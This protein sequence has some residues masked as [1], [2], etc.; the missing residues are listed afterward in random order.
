MLFSSAEVFTGG[1]YC[2]YS[3]HHKTDPDAK[4]QKD[5]RYDKR[6]HLIYTLPLK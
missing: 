1:V 2:I 4:D 5:E 3:H 6:Y